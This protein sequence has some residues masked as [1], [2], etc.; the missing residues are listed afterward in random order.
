MSGRHSSVNRLK[1]NYKSRKSSIWINPLNIEQK[2]LKKE[3]KIKS[4][5]FLI[6]LLFQIYLINYL[7]KKILNLKNQV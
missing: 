1:T 5:Y 6:L 7:K 3:K 4:I 2:K